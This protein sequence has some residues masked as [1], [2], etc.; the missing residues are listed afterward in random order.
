VYI[1]SRLLKN[2]MNCLYQFV[3]MLSH[4]PREIFW[5]VNVGSFEESG[6]AK[7]LLL[8]SVVDQ[9]DLDRFVASEIGTKSDSRNSAHRNFSRYVQ[10]FT[11]HLL[12][13]NRKEGKEK[14]NNCIE[15]LWETN[16]KS[17]IFM[18][19]QYLPERPFGEI[20][21]WYCLFNL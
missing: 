3:S 8:V 4:F 6:L 1:V 7:D 10:F 19:F 14:K 13:L 5:N 11:E 15:R 17:Y 16:R 20:W 21:P 12:D 18:M 9:T 2:K